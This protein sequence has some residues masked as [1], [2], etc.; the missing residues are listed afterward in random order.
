M[1]EH[2]SYIFG[3]VHDRSALN[4]RLFTVYAALLSPVE[5]ILFKLSD[6]IRV[7]RAQS[8]GF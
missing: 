3:S 6:T 1:L 5:A 8:Q 7:R 4:V 2:P